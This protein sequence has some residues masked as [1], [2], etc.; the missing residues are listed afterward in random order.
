LDLNRQLRDSSRSASIG[1]TRAY[2]IVRKHYCAAW[3]LAFIIP[4]GSLSGE[5]LKFSGSGARRMS[6]REVLGNQKQ[7]LANQ[8]T[9]IVNQK[10]IKVNQET[11]KK[12]QA[13]I[14]KNQATLNT[15]VSNQKTILSKLK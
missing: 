11:I 12:N 14:L 6:E 13:A 8:K 9:I 7:I 15:I 2:V 1:L 3:I 10:A 5:S 4:Y